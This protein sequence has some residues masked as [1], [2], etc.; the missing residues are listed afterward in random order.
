MLQGGAGEDLWS[1]VV[2]GHPD[3]TQSWPLGGLAQSEGKYSASEA[4]TDFSRS[5]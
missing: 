3:M 1:L 2:T 5:S 4:V